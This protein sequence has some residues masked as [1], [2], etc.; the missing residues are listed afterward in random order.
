[1]APK[2]TN[3]MQEHEMKELETAKIV[4]QT[5]KAT[6]EA[7]FE[8][9]NAA[10]KLLA[11]DNV[12]TIKAVVE[13]QT[14]V[15]NMKEQHRCFEIEIKQQVSDLYPKI[16][17]I[18]DKIDKIVLGRPTWVITTMLTILTSLV[19]GLAVFIITKL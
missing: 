9:A 16:K 5:A 4:A 15:E 17:E 7:V 12:D 11:K 14:N 18:F 3:E 2:K 19:V 10:A 8:A 6:A 1:M 13:L